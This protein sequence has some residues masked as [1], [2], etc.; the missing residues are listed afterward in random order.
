MSFGAAHRYTQLSQLNLTETVELLDANRDGL[1]S[2]DELH[3]V[4]ST[5]A[6]GLPADAVSS[7][8]HKLL[9]GQQALR[10]A[11]L[12]EMSACRIARPLACRVRPRH[13]HCPQTR[14]RTRMDVA[15][16]LSLIHI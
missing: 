9:R 8:T 16:C 7:L 6:M 10:I 11:D 14:S 5:F 15:V 1:V 2:F 4:M 12:L 3:G 13:S